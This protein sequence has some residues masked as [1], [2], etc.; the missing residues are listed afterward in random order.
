MHY[1]LCVPFATGEWTN[2]DDAVLHV[3]HYDWW[4]NWQWRL[5]DINTTMGTMVFGD[6]GW[7]DAHGGPVAANYFFAENVLQELDVPGEWC[8]CSKTIN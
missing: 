5:K 7:Q 6:G 8:V 4:G 3:I 1:N 2:V